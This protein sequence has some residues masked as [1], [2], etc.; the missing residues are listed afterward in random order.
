[1]ASNPL[2]ALLWLQGN[3]GLLVT[4]SHVLLTQS[5]FYCALFLCLYSVFV[6]WV[7]RLAISYCNDEAAETVFNV[8]VPL[9][10]LDYFF[11]SF[12]I[13]FA[14]NLVLVCVFSTH[15]YSNPV[16]MV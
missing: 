16:H 11:C 2:C 7:L 10:F 3:T 5:G 14:N 4:K 9:H 1:M 6:L 12:L 15:L 8:T 13:M